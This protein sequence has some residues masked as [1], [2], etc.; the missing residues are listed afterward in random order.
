L[1]V[2]PTVEDAGRVLL[3][4]HIFD[5]NQPCY[6]KLVKIEFLQ[7][8]REEKKFPDLESMTAAIHADAAHARDYFRTNSATDRI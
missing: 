8:I 5:Y 7:K 6:G 1:G 4:T 2:R 3:E